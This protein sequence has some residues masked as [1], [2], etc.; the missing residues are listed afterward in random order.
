MQRAWL[1]FAVLV[2]VGSAAAAPVA[3]REPIS[4]VRGGLPHDA[5][6]DVAFSDR[7]GV[8]VGHHGA[9]LYT[10]NGGV[11][12]VV[13]PAFTELALTAVALGSQGSIVVGQQGSIFVGEP[14]GDYEQV[15]SPTSERLMSVA[16][17]ESGVAVA[18]GGFGALLVSV[19]S[20]RTWVQADIDWAEMNDEGLEAHLYDVEIKNNGDILVCGEF[21]L[22]LQSNNL[23]TTWEAVHKGTESLFAMHLSA[24]GLG[25]AVGQDGAVLRTVD[26]GQSW[27]KLDSGTQTNLLD[28]WASK[29]D[30]V[31][32][33]GIRALLRS[34]DIG[35][36]WQ[37]AQGRAVERSWYQALAASVVDYPIENGAIH[38]AT[39]YAVGQMGN[40]ITVNR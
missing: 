28:V 15:E 34:S 27:Q 14:G 38:A 30:E 6:Y 31:V 25:F 18:V 40:I 17:H 5:L 19:D 3:A 36:T 2:L 26:H 1:R 24:K 13:R 16:L 10:T 32:V 29:E 7:V 37:A 21:G 4:L 12:W 23:G 39:V 11:D 9:N 8:A 22:V 33:V 20:G 35:N